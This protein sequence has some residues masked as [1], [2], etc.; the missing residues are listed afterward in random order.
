[1]SGGLVCTSNTD[2]TFTLTTATGCGFMSQL[3]YW[4][5]GDV[6]PAEYAGL[7]GK[8]VAV[9]CVSDATSYGTGNESLML[10]REVSGI[11]RQ[12]VK[13]I[14]LVRADEVADWIDKNGW[15]EID[16]R[17][18]GRGVKA[19]RVVAIDLEGLRLYESSALYKGR[20]DVS[21]TVYDMANGGQEVFHKKLPEQSFPASGPHPVGDTSESQFRRA[22]LQILGQNVSRYFHEYDLMEQ[23]SRDPAFIGT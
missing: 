14:D 13:E 2:A 17:E 7:Q 15:D 21:V 16:Y 18:V 3:M 23:F 1:M 11:L 6:V 10:A 19:D 5:N 9:I 22:F 8:R 20:A 4:K 12:H